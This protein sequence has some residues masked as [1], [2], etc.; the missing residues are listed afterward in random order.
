MISNIVHIPENFVRD[1]TALDADVL[2][3]DLLN[4]VR[5]EGK[6]KTMTDTLSVE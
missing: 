4:E 6:T 5:A 1:R 3:F 2:F